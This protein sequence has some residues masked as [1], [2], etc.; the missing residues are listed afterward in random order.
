MALCDRIRC[1]P[2]FCFAKTPD[3]IGVPRARRPGWQLIVEVGHSPAITM[4]PF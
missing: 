3:E 4:L 1:S 2:D